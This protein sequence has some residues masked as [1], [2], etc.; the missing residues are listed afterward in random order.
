MPFKNDI[1]SKAFTS[2]LIEHI[3]DENLVN[4]LKEVYR[5]MQNNAIFRIAC[6]DTD[7]AFEAYRNMR[8]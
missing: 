4:L 6:P 5:V 2:H 8:E 1:V 7:L 3:S